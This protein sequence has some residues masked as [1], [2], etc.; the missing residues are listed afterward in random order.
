[1]AISTPEQ[2][3][4]IRATVPGSKWYF[5]SGS[6]WHQKTVERVTMTLVIMTTGERVSKATR[7][8]NGL[9]WF[10]STPEMVELYE[11]EQLKAAAQ[12]LYLQALDNL[13]A[14]AQRATPAQ[15]RELATHMNEAIG[16]SYISKG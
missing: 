10:P 15:L 11:T 16:L 6:G 9:L 1:M 8:G 12:T 3:E 14:A 4:S 7:M 2:E 13:Q 5:R